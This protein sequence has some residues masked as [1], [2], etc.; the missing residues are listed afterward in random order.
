MSKSSTDESEKRFF[1]GD[2]EARRVKGAIRNKKAP[3]YPS[4][5]I[6]TTLKQLYV[7]KGD[8]KGPSLFVTE[9]NK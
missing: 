4:K 8:K 5:K 2:W 9:Q 6:K 3:L 1:S 7:K